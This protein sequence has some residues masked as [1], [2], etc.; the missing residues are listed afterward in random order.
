MVD[1]TTRYLQY[2]KFERAYSDH[3]VSNY[4][5]TLI[6]LM[7][8]SAEKNLV[9]WQD[10]D[11]T[12]LKQWIGQFKREG[13]KASSIQLHL[14]AV[15]GLFKYLVSKREIAI[16]PADLLVSPKQDRPLP[17]NLETDEVHHLLSFIPESDI[18]FRDKAY[19]E[20]FY[21]SGLRLA[22]LTGLDVVDVD[23]QECM[24]KVT[25]KGNKQRIVP[26]GSVAINAIVD[27]IK[28][29]PSLNKHNIDALF[30]SKLGNRLSAR[31]I[32]QRL[33][34][35]GQ[36][37]GMANTVHP[38]KLRHSF[39]THIL[40]SSADLRSVQELL[41]HANL[42]TTQIYTHLDFQHLAKVY[43]QAHPRAKKSN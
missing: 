20:L 12:L 7:T 24:V 19:M 2:L 1:L 40:E 18:E 26:V 21:S 14:S 32:Q 22:E 43:D 4:S 6:S 10:I 28:V 16:N 11:D 3:T 5:H 34:Y 42:S 17:K 37:L 29:R 31:Q 23:V 13:L 33:K 27:W 36:K 15:R 30:I 41:G 8:F 9:R 39:A 35:W 25:G 38:H